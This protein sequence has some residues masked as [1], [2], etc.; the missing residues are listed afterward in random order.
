MTFHV[1]R[2]QRGLSGKKKRRNM[3]IFHNSHIPRGLCKKRRI[4]MT[5]HVSR[6]QRGLSGEKKEGFSFLV[7]RYSTEKDTIIKFHVSHIQ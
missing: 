6:I 5:F 1:S 3:I 2:I 7:Q 4:I